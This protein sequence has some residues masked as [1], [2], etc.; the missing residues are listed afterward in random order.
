MKQVEKIEKGI[1]FSPKYDTYYVYVGFGKNRVVNAATLEMAQ[2]IKNE[3]LK[4]RT[5][6]K[7]A[8]Q[9]AKFN[10]EIK[11]LTID[12]DYSVLDYP[13]NIVAILNWDLK[14]LALVCNKGEKYTKLLFDTIMLDLGEREQKVIIEFFQNKK[15]MGEIGKIMGYTKVRI[16]QLVHKALK[17][18]DFAFKKLV[19]HEHLAQEKLQEFMRREGLKKET[20]KIIKEKV[21]D[22]SKGELYT[23]ADRLIGMSE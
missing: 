3:Y 1:I 5:E 19:E 14:D 15:S 18:I 16:S 7:V 23:L 4:E 22:L 13:N 12:N 20:I 8:Q 10:K 17:E 21:S 2:A 6:Y 9:R 11:E